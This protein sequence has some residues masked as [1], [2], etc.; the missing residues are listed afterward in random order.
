MDAQQQ[1]TFVGI[2]LIV[3]LGSAACCG[4]TVAV[5]ALFGYQE[6]QQTA[7]SG[8]RDAGTGRTARAIVPEGDDDEKDDTAQRERFADEILA[9]LADAGHTEY[10]YQAD[11]YDLVTDGGALISLANLYEEYADKDAIGRREFVERTVRGFFPAEVPTEWDEAAPH[12]VATVR[13]RI[14][15]E[16]LAIRSDTPLDVLQRPLSDDLVELVVYDGADSMQFVNEAHLEAW[17]RNADEVF[18]Q[19]RKQL[20][21]RSK[22]TFN[23][24]SPG[25]YESP[26]E[27]NHDIGRALLF[28]TLRR[29]KVKGEPV[30]FLPQRDHLLVTGANDAAGLEAVAELVSER[31]SLPRANTGRGWRLTRQGLVPFIPSPDDDILNVLRAEALAANA[32]EQKKALDEKFEREGTDIFVGTTLFTDDDDGKQ[33]SYCVWTKGAVTLM[34]KADFVVFIDLDE[35]EP[36]RVVAA[37]PWDDVVKKVGAKVS[38][39]DGYWPARYKVSVFPDARTIKAIGLHH[40]F[41]R[42]KDAAE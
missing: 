41:T 12:L 34:P 21:A 11:Q 17:A 38:L 30:I 22:D 31:L 6:A 19:G 27:D 18:L 9:G 1:K 42:N 25:V 7:A 37:G 36:D 16:L 15:V 32:N 26:W 4:L 3:L 23:S 8:G 13:D 39:E 2:V 14:F 20:A 28:E 5:G 24:P 40:F 29:L 33:T 10:V 35:P